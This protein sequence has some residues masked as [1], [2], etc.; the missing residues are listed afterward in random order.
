M[1]ILLN[2]QATSLPEG[3]T[4]A[5]AL[6]QLQPRPPFAVAINT[7]FV[8]KSRY[9]SQLLQAGDKMEVIAPVTGG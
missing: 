8:P 3:A 6:A 1:E 5:Q 4:V 7:Q 2:N 9:D